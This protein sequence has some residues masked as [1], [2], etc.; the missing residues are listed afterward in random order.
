MNQDQIKKMPCGLISTRFTEALDL[1]PQLDKILLSCPIDSWNRHLYFVDVKVHM[2]MPG[3]YPCIPNWH[4]DFVPRD[5]DGIKQ[6][7]M[8]DAR[9]KMFLWLSGPPIT[10][11]RDGREVVPKEWMEFTQFDEHRGVI[12]DKFQWRLFIRVAP[13]NLIPFK[14]KGDDR[15]RR[16]TQVYLNADNFEW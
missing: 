13:E 5:G 1:M 15:I 6:W 3:Q 4:Y 16:H 12:S 8:R 14:A 10:Q 9:N 2:L 7:H 11:F